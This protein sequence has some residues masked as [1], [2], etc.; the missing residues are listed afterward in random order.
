MRSLKATRELRDLIPTVLAS[1]SK[2]VMCIT[3]APSRGPELSD[4]AARGR[5]EAGL[6][7]GR[8]GAVMERCV[9][10][11]LARLNLLIR[12]GG[13]DERERES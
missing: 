9:G 3:N 6:R 8:G 12:S 11:L 10:A 1:F 7:A 13:S 2:C 4:E 5:W